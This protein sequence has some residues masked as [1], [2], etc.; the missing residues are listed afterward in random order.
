MAHRLSA[1]HRIVCLFPLLVT[2]KCTY[3]A[4]R[5]DLRQDAPTADLWII[6][7]TQCRIRRTGPGL[8]GAPPF[9]SG[10]AVFYTR[11]VPLFLPGGCRPDDLC[12][13]AHSKH[14]LQHGA[15]SGVQVLAWAAHRRF[16][17]AAKAVT[18]DARKRH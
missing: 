5:S 1:H 7:D 14:I 8:G 2:H 10:L 13:R 17:T 18:Q 4:Y 15:S 11:S 6:Q 12:M 3:S 16:A 9:R